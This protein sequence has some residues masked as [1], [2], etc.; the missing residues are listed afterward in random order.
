MLKRRPIARLHLTIGL[1][2]L[3]ATAAMWGLYAATDLGVFVILAVFLQVTL[4]VGIAYVVITTLAALPDAL[5]SR[6]FE[7]AQAHPERSRRVA[8]VIGLA[9]WTAFVVLIARSF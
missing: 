9:A 5:H 8:K 6:W 7:W 3:A 2:T 1:V 4:M